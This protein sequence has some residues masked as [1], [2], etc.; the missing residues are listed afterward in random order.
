MFY[1]TKIFL[2]IF[3]SVASLE[4]FADECTQNARKVIPR[5]NGQSFKMAI[6]H[7]TK[8]ENVQITLYEEP[9]HQALMRAYRLKNVQQ[10]RPTSPNSYKNLPLRLLKSDGYYDEII[11]SSRPYIL[12]R[13]RPR[14]FLNRGDINEGDIIVPFNFKKGSFGSKLYC[15]L[16]LAQRSGHVILLGCYPRRIHITGKH[17]LAET[18][19]SQRPNS[20]QLLTPEESR[21]VISVLRTP[22]HQ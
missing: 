14:G 10:I 11:L 17:H 18:L 2:L 22:S 3:L 16:H 20:F 6:T 7:P 8:A 13:K 21:A 19:F 15:H 9:L 1:Q 4:I 12:E 5:E